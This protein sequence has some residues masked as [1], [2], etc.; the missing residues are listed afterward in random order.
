MDFYKGEEKDTF[1]VIKLIKRDEDVI[2][3]GNNEDLDENDIEE[4]SNEKEIFS[5]FEVEPL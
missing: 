5:N 3:D 1:I 4:T 2:D